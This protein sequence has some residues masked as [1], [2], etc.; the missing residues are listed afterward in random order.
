MMAGCPDFEGWRK[1][2]KGGIVK[3]GHAHDAGP[4]ARRGSSQ[5]GD[6]L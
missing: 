2:G 5:K 4:K 3:D 6:C 1:R